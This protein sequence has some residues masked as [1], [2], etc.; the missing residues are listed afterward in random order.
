MS[1]N[2]KPRSEVIFDSV[3]PEDEMHRVIVKRIGSNYVSTY[4]VRVDNAWAVIDSEVYSDLDELKT[5]MRIVGD[6]E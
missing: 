1:R 5:M 4:Y 6:C 2:R 3:Y